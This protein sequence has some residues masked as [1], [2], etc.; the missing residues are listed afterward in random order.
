[1]G[2]VI[3]F[4]CCAAY[5]C[6]PKATVVRGAAGSRLATSDPRCRWPAS[7]DVSPT[8]GVGS[9]LQMIRSMARRAAPKR[10]APCLHR[11]SRRGVCSGSGSLS[12]TSRSVRRRTAEAILRASAS[13]AWPSVAGRLV[14]P[15]L[16]SKLD[17]PATFS[18]VRVVPGSVPSSR[19][20][21]T[22]TGGRSHRDRVL[23]WW[24]ACSPSPHAPEGACS[25]GAIGAS[26]GGLLARPDLSCSRGS[27]TAGSDLGDLRTR[28]VPDRAASRRPG[29]SRLLASPPV[30][31][32]VVPSR[33]PR[34]PVGSSNPAGE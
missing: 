23:V 6:G 32:V 17:R 14:P 11:S 28:C 15:G 2:F 5:P 1:M 34:R 27:L 12:F 19:V 30:A 33:P 13:T 10:V 22:A 29:R 8:R 18:P 9:W 31:L 25:A 3:P 7:H 4:P 26:P 21:V 24:F 20:R 16:S